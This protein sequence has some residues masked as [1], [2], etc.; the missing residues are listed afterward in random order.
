MAVS[1]IVGS[2]NS[3][4]GGGLVGEIGGGEQLWWLN[5]ENLTEFDVTAAKLWVSQSTGVVMTF[6]GGGEDEGKG[7]GDGECWGGS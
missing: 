7:G 4:G 3:T 5:V 6:S 1:S 2:L